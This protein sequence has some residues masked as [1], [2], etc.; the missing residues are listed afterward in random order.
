MHASTNHRRDHLLE[1]F[2]ATR[3]LQHQ[4]SRV[5]QEVDPRIGVIPLNQLV[6]RKIAVNVRIGV[7]RTLGFQTTHREREI[8][9]MDDL[10]LC[11]MGG[12][13][14]EQGIK[15]QETVRRE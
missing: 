9:Q 10:I 3:Y 2:G 13:A 11:F 8:L 6:E 14:G 4:C 1:G 5:D 12:R 7:Q 15:W